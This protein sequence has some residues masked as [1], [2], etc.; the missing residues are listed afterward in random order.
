MTYFGGQDN[1]IFKI[2][3][4]E[5]FRCIIPWRKDVL[6]RYRSGRSVAR[7]QVQQRLQAA[8]PTR[9]KNGQIFG[10]LLRGADR[11]P[12]GQ[13]KHAINQTSYLLPA[14]R[15]FSVSKAR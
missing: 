8:V 4:L 10:H 3:L 9:P 2:V 13:R 15:T 14:R 7:A 12:L 1:F 6:N 5:R 11:P